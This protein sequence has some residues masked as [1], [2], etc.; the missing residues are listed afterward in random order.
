MNDNDLQTQTDENI[1]SANNGN[2]K[3]HKI[4]GV[5]KYPGG[6]S[7]AAWLG[8]F[9]ATA[10][11]TGFMAWGYKVGLDSVANIPLQNISD[12]TNSYLFVTWL[13]SMAS[14]FTSIFSGVMTCIS[15]K[16]SKTEYISV[17]AN[18]GETLGRGR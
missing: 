1:V 17:P 6:V 8:C 10:A 2:S 15:S 16:F 5:T 9:A 18:D 3:K 12:S 7:P 13:G 11:L 4:V 14:G